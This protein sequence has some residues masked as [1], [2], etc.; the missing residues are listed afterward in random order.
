MAKVRPEPTEIDYARLAAYID[1]E[2]TIEI[3]YKHK[4]RA[5]F[6]CVSIDNTDPRL[7]VW[8]YETFGGFV[9]SDHSSKRKNIKWRSKMQWYIACGHAHDLLL[10]CHPF[11][12]TKGDQADIAIAFRKT[13]CRVGV[14]GHPP[15]VLKLRDQMREDLKTLRHKTYPENY[16]DEIART[17]KSPRQVVN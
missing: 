6:L 9:R 11:F 3:A 15:E 13:V 10:K 4:S 12:I 8:L 17:S 1:G 5:H 2:G 16:L 7:I 14:K